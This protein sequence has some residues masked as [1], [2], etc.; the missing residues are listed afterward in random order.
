MILL[1]YL[2]WVT[3]NTDFF[4][5]LFSARDL[6]DVPLHVLKSVLAPSKWL[7]T[8]GGGALKLPWLHRGGQSLRD[9]PLLASTGSGYVV[10]IYVDPHA[11]PT[12][13][14]ADQLA[15]VRIG[16]LQ[17]QPCQQDS[18]YDSEEQGNFGKR[19]PEKGWPSARSVVAKIHAKDKVQRHDAGAG[20][21]PEAEARPAFIQPNF[22]P[23]ERGREP[24]Q[25][26]RFL[27]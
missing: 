5:P 10:W 24:K 14:A 4:G 15:F 6:V 8:I 9:K 1:S 25:T 2:G 23:L 3:L 11:Q 26:F 16:W 21:E 20:A 22:S 7:R 18:A 12:T 19:A 17:L 27:V 13:T